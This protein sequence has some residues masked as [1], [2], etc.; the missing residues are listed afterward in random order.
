MRQLQHPAFLLDQVLRNGPLYSKPELE[1]QISP[2]TDVYVERGGDVLG[3]V[4]QRLPISIP[5]F[6]QT[7]NQK[8]KMKNKRIT[9]LRSE[10]S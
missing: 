5:E 3:D 2:G 4:L 6:A 7:S 10:G 8:L 9:V 1:I